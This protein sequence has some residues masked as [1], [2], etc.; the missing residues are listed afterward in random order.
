MEVIH[1]TCVPVPLLKTQAHGHAEL[2]TKLGNV[3]RLQ[4]SEK[5]N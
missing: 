5:W 1:I 2:H 4:A 3:V